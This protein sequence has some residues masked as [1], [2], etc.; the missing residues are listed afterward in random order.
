MA[1]CVLS[2]YLIR[3]LLGGFVGGGGGGSGADLGI[4]Y[5]GASCIGEGF[6]DL[7]GP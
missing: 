7:L 5:R 2:T 6:G 3:A 4:H 1:M